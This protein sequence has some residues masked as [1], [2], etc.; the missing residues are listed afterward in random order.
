MHF[1]YGNGLAEIEFDNQGLPVALWPIPAWRVKP[2]RTQTQELFYQVT[3]P[4]GGM[5]NLPPYRIWHLMGL[6][7]D[8]IWGMSVIGQ[9]R[10]SIGL[11]IATE[12]F[13]ARFFSG[14][15]NVGGVAQHPNE[16]TEQRHANACRIAW[17]SNMR[18]WGKATGL[19]YWKKV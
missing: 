5:K 12:E 14:G 15:A 16:L 1:L 6:S 7:T 19:C 17:M 2:L 3:L 4:D 8:G 13:G 9:A 10:E 11:A 18:A